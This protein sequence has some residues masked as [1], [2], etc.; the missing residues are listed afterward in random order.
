MYNYIYKENN[1]GSKMATPQITTNKIINMIE[2][3][4]NNLRENKDIGLNIYTYGDTLCISYVACERRNYPIDVAKKYKND[5]N[6]FV[7]IFN[8]TSFSNNNKLNKLD[9]SC[10]DDDYSEYEIEIGRYIQIKLGKKQS[11]FFDRF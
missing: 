11:K 3:M 8:K 6:N 5:I 2:D 4:K 9:V 1:K 7:T 10:Y